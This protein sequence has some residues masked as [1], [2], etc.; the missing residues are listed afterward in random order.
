MLGTNPA[1]TLQC[2][3]CGLTIGGAPIVYDTAT[4]AALTDALIYRD[5]DQAVRVALA[6][7]AD[8][9]LEVAP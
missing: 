4:R 3:G 1:P 8:G 6:A 2:L 7:H 5:M 9:L